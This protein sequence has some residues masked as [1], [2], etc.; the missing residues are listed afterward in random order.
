MSKLNDLINKLL[1]KAQ[2]E[3][4]LFP[5]YSMKREGRPMYSKPGDLIEKL[6]VEERTLLQTAIPED[7]SKRRMD[8][9]PGLPVHRSLSEEI[10]RHMPKKGK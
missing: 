7:F 1:D 10:K 3:T 5:H 2:M 4:L 6:T 8:S 9:L